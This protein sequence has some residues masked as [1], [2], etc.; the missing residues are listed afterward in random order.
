MYVLRKKDF[1]INVVI[2][3]REKIKYINEENSY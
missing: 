1:Y 3:N 2:K